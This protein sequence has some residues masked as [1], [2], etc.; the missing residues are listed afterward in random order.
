MKPH[1]GLATEEEWVWEE[2]FAKSELR[3]AASH[4]VLGLSL[5]FRGRAGEV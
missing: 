2:E 4:Q 5:H 3:T 1:C